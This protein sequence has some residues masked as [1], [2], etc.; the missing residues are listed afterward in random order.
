MKKIKTRIL[1][2]VLAFVM[3][4]SIAMGMA[5]MNVYAVNVGDVV[6]RFNYAYDCQRSPAFPQK[7]SSITLSGFDNPYGAGESSGNW[8]IKYQ[9]KYDTAT[10]DDKVGSLISS[11]AYYYSLEVD[12]YSSV[13]VYTLYKNGAYVC[14]GVVVGTFGEGVLFCGTALPDTGAGYYLSNVVLSDNDYFQESPTGDLSEPA[15]IVLPCSHNVTEVPKKD[16]TCVEEGYEAHYKCTDCDKLFSDSQGTYVINAPVVISTDDAAHVGLTGKDERGHWGTCTLCSMPIGDEDNSEIHIDENSDNKCDSCGYAVYHVTLNANGLTVGGAKVIDTDGYRVYRI[17]DGKTFLVPADCKV[18][19]ICYEEINNVVAPGAKA[20]LV[21]GEGITNTGCLVSD[22]TYDT[23]I[24]LNADAGDVETDVNVNDEAPIQSVEIKNS[25]TEF[26]EATN[27][28]TTAEISRILTGADARVWL[29]VNKIDTIPAT[30]KTAIENKV[31]QLGANT[32]ITYFDASLFKQVGNDNAQTVSEP[33]MDIEI[34]ISIPQSLLNTD[35]TKTRT[36]QLL[37]Y[38][39]GE[40]VTVIDGTFSNGK[41]TFTTNKFSTYAIIYK[42]TVLSNQDDGN[43]DDGNLGGDE[44]VE[45]PDTGDTT[46][47]LYV[48]SLMLI[49]ALGVYLTVEKRKFEKKEN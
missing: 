23:V 33:G 1:S 4:F 24:V 6:Y 20:V 13:D 40:G 44:F 2:S 47:S 39:E 12:E 35:T 3:I 21:A 49:S 15:P 43:Q 37:R 48:M 29:D 17:S 36:Y 11:L 32:N 27:I 14:D 30:Q 18:E 5:P 9:G 7:G 38:H 46:D 25:I 34:T 42:D 8:E 45:V 41:F 31:A 22:F 19:V 16:A 26:I 28:F 10:H